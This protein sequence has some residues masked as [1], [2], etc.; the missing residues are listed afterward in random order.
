MESLLKFVD[1]ANGYIWGVGMLVLIA[2]AG[3]YFT[4][5]LRFFQFV[6]F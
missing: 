3:I 5:R 1:W 6:R 2:G 4:V